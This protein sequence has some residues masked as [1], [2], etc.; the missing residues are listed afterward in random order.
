MRNV[1]VIL[2]ISIIFVASGNV[3]CENTGEWSVSHGGNV[4]VVAN[5]GQTDLQIKASL[6]N[7]KASD[8]WVT[9]ARPLNKGNCRLVKFSIT[10]PSA[11][12]R[13]MGC[14]IQDSTGNTYTFYKNGE[15][16]FSDVTRLVFSLDGFRDKDGNPF[17][18]DAVPAGFRITFGIGAEAP[19]EY[20]ISD[21]R[22]EEPGRLPADF[23]QPGSFWKIQCGNKV[24]CH[25][26]YL[27]D[28]NETAFFCRKRDPMNQGTDEWVLAEFPVRENGLQGKSEIEFQLKCSIAKDIYFESRVKDAEGNIFVSQQHIALTPEYRSVKL[29]FQ[30]MKQAKSTGK[31]IAPEKIVGISFVF[32]LNANATLTMRDLNAVEEKKIARTLT[33]IPECANAAGLFEANQECILRLEGDFPENAA[34]VQCRILDYFGK[35]VHTSILK[36]K[37]SLN[38]GKLPPGYYEIQIF[39]I[40]QDGG[41]AEQS[42]IK[43]NGW[44]NIPGLATFAV[45]PCTKEENIRDIRKYGEKSFYG[46]MNWQMQFQI[47]E[48]IGAP[49]H[50][51]GTQWVW[52][53][54]QRQDEIING[55]SRWVC[56]KMEEPKHPDYYFATLSL[57]HMDTRVV[58]K[59]ATG[60]YNFIEFANNRMESPEYLQYI[61]NAVTLYKYRYS[62]MKKRI[63]EITWE[64]NHH[65]APYGNHTVA[66]VVNYYKKM[67][68]YIKS[69]DPDALFYGPK[70]NVANYMPWNRAIF[71]AGVGQYLNAFSGHFYTSQVPENGKL[72]EEIA[73]IRKLVK[74]TTGKTMAIHNTEGGYYSEDMGLIEQARRDVRYALIMQGEGVE[75]M[76]LFYLC[77]YSGEK[78]TTWGMFFNDHPTGECHPKR[79]MP[80]PVVPAYSVAAS[81]LRGAE[82]LM[83]LHWIGDNIWGYVF[84]KEQKTVIPLWS[85]YYTQTINFPVGN[86]KQVT[87][88]DIM[89]RRNVLPVK[90]GIVSLALSPDVIYLLDTD[91]D[92]WTGERIGQSPNN[93]IIPLELNT[94]VTAAIPVKATDN[95]VVETFGSIQLV[96][97]GELVQIEIPLNTP[98]GIVPIM[99]KSQNKKQ[100]L[101]AHV[102]PSLLLKDC[103]MTSEN[104]TMVLHV[105]IRNTSAASATAELSLTTPTGFCYRKTLNFPAQTEEI[106]K[107]PVMQIS[108]NFNP[109][110]PF[111]GTF[112]LNHG[113]QISQKQFEY[114]FLAA[115]D[116]KNKITD[117]LFANTINLKG[118]GASGQDDACI[119]TFERAPVSLNIQVISKDDVF[120][121]PVDNMRIW[122]YDSLQLAFDTDPGNGFEYDELTGRT[123]K[124]VTSLGFAL[125]PRGIYAHRYATCNEKILKTGDITQDIPFTIE[126]NNGETIY[127]LQIPWRQIGL[128]PAEAVA[129]KKIGV[130]LLINDSDGEKTERKVISLYGGIFDN[131][132]WRNYGILNLR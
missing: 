91:P 132:G 34:S 124:K 65:C 42:C 47:H 101:Y 50:Q 44:R 126:R 1:I 70:G 122:L 109:A 85:P 119:I 100:I 130:S 51:E 90:N 114:Y 108:E 12:I 53:E 60:K 75:F 41:I 18:N 78:Y 84:L 68:P 58:P 3:F 61:K 37:T 99:F 62:H 131:S 46:I 93:G 15:Y 83:N 125:T 32:V 88:V 113:G 102:N 40:F 89:G 73:A 67:V 4:Q 118:K 48:L 21:F 24:L 104:G 19:L 95:T 31:K 116:E 107:I 115:K 106:I 5:G 16:Y 79:L 2:L 74:E 8:N 13:W 117:P 128:D 98:P 112:Q 14:S 66:D 55:L 23:L 121:Q 39:P 63:Y 35:T 25:A 81:L 20:T 45:M 105:P 6:K 103:D 9:L 49:W 120:H 72:P 87:V 97:N 92:I 69:I 94:G 26:D 110:V 76:M 54:Y 36:K 57:S 59:W 111:Q 10:S 11:G 71:E 64:P 43:T 33:V 52:T 80:K 29:R 28:T 7:I 96:R 86:V 38:L 30:D 129:G 22:Q 56:K 27:A 82:P 123:A 17:P 127:K 77:D